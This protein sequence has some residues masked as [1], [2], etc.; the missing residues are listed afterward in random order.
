MCEGYVVTGFFYN[1]NI[2]PVDEYKKRFAQVQVASKELG[3]ELFEGPYDREEWF[4][5]AKGNEY[6]KEG[7]ERCSICFRMRLE[8]T[9]EYFKKGDFSYFT[10]TLSVSPHKNVTLINKIGMDIGGDKFLLRDFKKQDGF[11]RS[12][13]LSKEWHLY[14]QHYC[15][16]IYSL[17]NSYEEK[18]RKNI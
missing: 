18:I 16:C 5:R 14:R 13:E 12:Q 7:G 2:H 8:K 9:Y 4:L 1:P 3:F 11:K 10:T 6:A 15:G 17:E